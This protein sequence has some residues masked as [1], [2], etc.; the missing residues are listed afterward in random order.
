MKCPL[1]IDPIRVQ[2]RL[3]EFG[4]SLDNMREVAHAMS[5]EMAD[6][7][8]NDAPGAAGSRAYFIGVR[9]NREVHCVGNSGWV[10]DDT[11]FIASVFNAKTRIKIAVANTDAG[12]GIPEF[13]PTN[14]S[15]KGAAA[16]RAI[17][18]NRQ[19][20][21]F[22][23]LIKESNNVVPLT[24]SNHVGIIL[25]YYLCV[26]CEGEETRAE[27]S[28]PIK[29]DGKYFSDFHERVKIIGRDGD[30]D[31]GGRKATPSEEFDI[32]VIRKTA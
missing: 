18:G 11:D 17:A 13:A 12:T 20:L 23:E 28:C 27:L 16:G 32:P 2:N 21:E 1:V 15:A 30:D 26:F 7:S 3:A 6:T 25:C 31:L 4:T 9:R 29:W 19:Q 10:K 24:E 22:E 14:R 5:S 8:L